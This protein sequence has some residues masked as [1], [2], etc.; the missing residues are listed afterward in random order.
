M[1]PADRMQMRLQLAPHVT[2]L[3]LRYNWS[4]YRS[5]VLK[6]ESLE[7]QVPLPEPMAFHRVIH[8]HEATLYEKEV[9]PAAAALLKA[10]ASPATLPEVF[11]RM[12]EL[13]QS[14]MQD[15]EANLTEWFADFVSR[16]WIVAAGETEC[17]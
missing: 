10:L 9:T 17:G 6:D 16:G 8:R 14:D 4:A 7:L 1:D 13:S 11:E 2:A 12:P 15:L 3:S 5:Q